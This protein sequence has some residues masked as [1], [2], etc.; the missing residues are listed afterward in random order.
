MQDPRNN[1]SNPKV[2]VWVDS[3]GCIS[4][5]ACVAICPQ[6]FQFWDD[7]KS[8]AIAQPKSLEDLKCSKEAEEACPVSVI[9]LEDVVEEAP[10]RVNNPNKWN[11]AA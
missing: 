1:G 5:G 10:E 4:C 11:I 7:G 9:H 6:I 2:K 3:E 8:H